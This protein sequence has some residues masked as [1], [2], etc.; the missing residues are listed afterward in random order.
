[1]PPTKADRWGP[2]SR[3][4]AIVISPYARRHFVDH[5]TYDTTAILTTIEH[6]WHL[7]PL[8]S[9]DRDGHD[10]SSAF[11]FSQSS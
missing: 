4:P 5:T 11:D 8:S 9:R 7:D 10:L 3:V 2:V 1:V 6:R